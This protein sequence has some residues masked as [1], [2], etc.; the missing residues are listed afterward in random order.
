MYIY[1]NVY[2]CEY[3]DASTCEYIHACMCVCVCVCVMINMMKDIF[4]LSFSGDVVFLHQF[5]PAF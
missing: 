5:F 4:N 1:M 3:V 2:F